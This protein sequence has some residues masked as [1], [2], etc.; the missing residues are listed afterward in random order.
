MI[1]R[2]VI[3]AKDVENITGK[4]NQ[5]ARRLLKKIKKQLG[6]APQEFVTMQD[7][8]LVT[9]IPEEVVVPFLKY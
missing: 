8:C 6:K 5:A 9:G 1:H 3:Y 2:V 4:E 7:F